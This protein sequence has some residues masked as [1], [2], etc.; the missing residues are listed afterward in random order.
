MEVHMAFENIKKLGSNMMDAAQSVYN[1]TK[2]VINAASTAKYSWTDKAPKDMSTLEKVGY[3]RMLGN[4][5]TARDA[6]SAL[7]KEMKTVGSRHYSPY[8]TNTSNQKEAMEFFGVKSFDQDWLNDNRFLLNYVNQLDLTDTVSTSGQK[9]WSQAQ[10]AGYYYQMLSEAEKTTQQAENEWAQLRADM[11]RNFTEHKRLYGKAPGYEQLMGYIDMSDYSTLRKMDG[12]YDNVEDLV[13]LNRPVNYTPETMLGVY[14]ALE[15]GK[16]VTGDG[17]WF[18]AEGEELIARC[19][20]HELD[21]LDGILYIN[22][23]KDWTSFDVVAKL[24]KVLHTKSI[25]HTGTLDPDATGVLPAEIISKAQ[26]GIIMSGFVSIAAGLIVKRFGA[27]K[28]EKFM[29]DALA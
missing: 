16:D 20:C 5:Q 27:E 14:A 10:W 9:N 7:S 12:V 26:F 18:E 11:Q 6:F 23:P 17:N 2:N 22:K 25:G 4:D 24:R 15:S 19:F 13:R 8:M 21:H 3:L 28:V 29:A 1:R